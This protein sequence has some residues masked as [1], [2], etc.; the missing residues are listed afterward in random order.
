MEL[1]IWVV[2]IC[3]D[4]FFVALSSSAALLPISE[5]TRSKQ[6]DHHADC[7]N[8]EETEGRGNE[9]ASQGETVA[10]RLSQIF[11]GLAS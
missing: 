7:E 4:Y 3:F 1:R 10:M 2:L 5:G 8:K 6:P 11:S 9:E